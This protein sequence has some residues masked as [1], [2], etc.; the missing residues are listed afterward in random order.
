MFPKD[1]TPGTTPDQG[2]P[3][4]GRQRPRA[5]GD[6]KE[7][8]L[9]RE[10]CSRRGAGGRGGEAA[11]WRWRV[12]DGDSEEEGEEGGAFAMAVTVTMEGWERRGRMGDGEGRTENGGNAGRRGERER[13][14][15]LEKEEG[16]REGKTNVG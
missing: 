13:R 9:W 6:G 12:D 5:V 7:A 2:D 1:A 10:G 11:D 14:L 16:R 3:V 4:T 15:V 8:A